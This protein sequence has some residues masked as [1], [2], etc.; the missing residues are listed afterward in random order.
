MIDFLSDTQRDPPVTSQRSS[1]ATTPAASRIYRDQAIEQRIAVAR[2]RLSRIARMQGVSAASVEDVV[3]ETLLESWRALNKLRSP[4]RFDAWLDGICRNVCRRWLRANTAVVAREQHV[5]VPSASTLPDDEAQDDIADPV[6]LDLDEAL[7]REELTT[8]VDRALSHLHPSARK[9]VVLR[10]LEEQPADEVAR[11]LG[12]SVNALDVRLHR[13]RTQLRGLL[14]GVLRSDAEAFGLPLDPVTTAGRQETR[15]WCPLCGERRLEAEI[16]WTTGE[17]HYRCQDCG[18]FA[19]SGGPELLQGVRGYRPI[20]TRVLTR[21]MHQYTR[22]LA[23]GTLVC[24]CGRVAHVRQGLPHDTPEEMVQQIR[25]WPALHIRCPACG[26][27]ET[28]EI[29]RLTIDRPETQRFWRQHPH[30]RTLPPRELEVVG[31]QAVL[32]SVESVADSARLDLIWA[33]DTLQVLSVHG[34]GNS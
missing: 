25:G 29:G 15:I 3:Q 26:L 11:R 4:Q 33:R 16:N 9:A 22:G 23:T 30:V 19:A 12:I 31:Q 8:L 1:E 14:G 21:L 5:G 28:N 34:G 18:H 10:C 27:L 6:T 2:P 7:T 13:A 24:P 20:L 17:T 32:M